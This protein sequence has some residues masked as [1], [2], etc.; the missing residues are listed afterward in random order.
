MT[1]TAQ[2]PATQPSNHRPTWAGILYDIL[3]LLIIIIGL[4]LVGIDALLMSN[5]GQTLAT[6]SNLSEP[7][8]LYRTDLHTTALNIEDWFTVFLIAELLARWAL[9]IIKQ[10]YHRW[11]IFPFVH[12]YE[13]LGCIP[14]LRAFRLLRAVAIIRK[15]HLMGIQV[16][17]KRWM[18]FGQFYYNVILEEI[19]D[20]IVINVLDGIERELKNS[21]THGALIHNLIDQHRVQL[22]EATAELLQTSLAPALAQHNEQL[23]QGVGEAVHRAIANTPELHQMLRLI[24][25]VGGQIEKQIQAIGKRL[26]ENITAELVQP[27]RATAQAD[28]LAN[29]ALQT[30][31]HHVGN[32]PIDSPKLEALVESLVFEGIEMLRQQVAVQQWKQQSVDD[33][34]KA[35]EIPSH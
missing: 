1:T 31:A 14:A 6:W 24:P 4:L 11:F 20:R 35:D 3:I 19:S 9:A 5:V 15:L 29:P 23:Q 32:L 10:R 22:T 25:I 27:F 2:P 8:N 30:V 33:A 26:G 12:W 28:Q 17:P 7:L 21:Q 13:V 34:V 18:R 16:I